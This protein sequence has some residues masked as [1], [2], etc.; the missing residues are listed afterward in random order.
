MTQLRQL[1]E[2]LKKQSDQ[3]I[4]LLETLMFSKVNF[5]NFRV[6]KTIIFGSLKT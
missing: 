1:L 6:I 3:G 5:M 4:H 2:E